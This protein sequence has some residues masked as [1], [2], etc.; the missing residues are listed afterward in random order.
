ME[1]GNESV[2]MNILYIDHYIGSPSYGM[3]FR[4]YHMAL[5]WIKKGHRVQMLGASYSH[6]R[7]RQP[8]IDGR[9]VSKRTTENIDGIE[10]VWYPT[11]AYR[12]NGL[13]RVLNIFAF[14]AR[15]FLDA[16]RLV[17]KFRP[18]AVIASSTYPMDIWVARRIARKSS[19]RLV[20][21]IHDLWPLS[22]IE[23]GGM[24]PGHP[25]VRLCQKAEN[26]AYRDVDAVVSILPNVRQHVAEHGL[27]LRKLFVVPNGVVPE[28]WR[29]DRQ[30]PLNDSEITTRIGQL[31]AEGKLV[32][33]YA[34]AHGV[35]NA[36]SVLLEA[37][38]LLEQERIAFVFVGG[39]LAKED[40]L[41]RA[42]ALGLNS[43]Y[44]FG[45]VPKPQIL[46]LLRWF[47]VAYIGLQN[48]ALFRF[49]ISPNKLADYMMS[50]KVVLFACNAANDWVTES[51]CGVAVQAEDPKAVADGIRQLRRLTPEERAEMGKRGK[52]FILKNFT[53]ER[54]AER[55]LEAMKP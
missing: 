40:L 9:P 7:A 21:E 25:F 33:G 47:D 1:G 30:Q 31:R 19:A 44:F 36:L 48:R 8:E 12:G 39:G 52:E 4:P 16:N 41:Q 20:Y 46:A 51:G 50:G 35:P 38:K 49:G 42:K 37:A 23:L 17:R 15:V 55:F 5:E 28:D 6:V 10:Y 14:L 3:E 32:V 22:P 34:G 43:V 13:G 45:S 26:D 2:P 54:L 53:Y 24:S 27:D 29:E 11:P 18:D